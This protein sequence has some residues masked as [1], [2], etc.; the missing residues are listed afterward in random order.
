[1]LQIN[2]HIKSTFLQQNPQIHFKGKVGVVNN[3]SKNINNIDILQVEN[4]KKIV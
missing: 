3:S 2:P 4:I 1:M